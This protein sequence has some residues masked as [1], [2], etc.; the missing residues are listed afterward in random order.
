MYGSKGIDIND[1]E[2]VEYLNAKINTLKGYNRTVDGLK[3]A[4]RR[5][6]MDLG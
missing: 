1:I 4:I 5:D 3:V 2:A 6:L